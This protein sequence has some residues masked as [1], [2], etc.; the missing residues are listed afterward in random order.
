VDQLALTIS[1]TFPW[2]TCCECSSIAKLREHSIAETAPSAQIAKFLAIITDNEK[3][4]STSS[5][6]FIV[7]V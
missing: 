3:N 6:K 2:M 1:I 7:A 5:W 4:K